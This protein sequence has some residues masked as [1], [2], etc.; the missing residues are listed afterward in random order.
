MTASVRHGVVAVYIV[1]IMFSA[2][3]LFYNPGGR[4]LW[5][6]EAETAVLAA[7]VMKYGLPVSTDGKNTITLYG[8]AVDSNVNNVWTWRPWLDEYLT[9]ASFSLMGKSTAAARLPF[10]CFGFL[11]AILL[12]RLVYIIYENHET[13]IIAMLCLITSELFILHARQCRY[14][15]VVIF[16]EVW[17][18]LGLYWLIRGRGG[19]GSFHMAMA[20]A[21]AFYCNYIIV[22]GNIIA[23]VF[24]A[25]LVHERRRR[26]WRYVISGLAAFALMAAPWILYAKPWTQAGQLNNRLYIPKLHYYAVEIN[27]HMFPFILLLIPAAYFIL[28]RLPGGKHISAEKTPAE[29]VQKDVETFFVDSNTPSAC[30][31]F[32]YAGVVC[33]LFRTSYPCVLHPSGCAA[34]EICQRRHFEICARWAFVFHQSSIHFGVVF[35]SVW[36]QAGIA[37]NQLNALYRH[38]IHQQTGRCCRVSQQRGSPGRIHYGLRFRVSPD[39]LYRYAD[40]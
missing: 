12:A 2:V 20:L 40:N 35:F 32:D 11:S 38:A 9:A 16:A 4:A 15:S 26:I 28:R 23:I 21:V 13:T 37:D 19:R 1:F 17:L 30:H 3:A 18:I 34:Y 22:I 24:T 39:I 8:K 7:N 10:A 5:G 27:F 29:P 6:D 25:I 31:N 14:Y 33:A 36:P